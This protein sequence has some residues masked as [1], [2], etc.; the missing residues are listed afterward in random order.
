MLTKKSDGVKRLTKK[1][2]FAL[3]GIEFKDDKI[4]CPVFGWRPLLLKE[5]NSKT[6]KHVYTWS[7]LPT[8]ETFNV[9]IDGTAYA[10]KGTCPCHCKGCY[11]TSG[12]YNCDNVIQSMGINTYLIRNYPD[13]V[14]AALIAQI[15]AE[16]L[17]MVRIDA[18]G[19]IENGMINVFRNVVTACTDTKFWTY[20][21][22]K[23]VETAFDDLDNINIVKSV[24]PGIGFNYGHCDYIMNAFEKLSAAGEK[25]YICRCGV[26]KNQHCENCRGCIDNKYVLFV[27]HSTEYCAEKDP[28]YPEL[29]AL[30][31]SQSRDVITC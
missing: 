30:I 1:D 2:I 3:H 11:A 4:L 12:R 9:S 14:T 10:I 19:D 20:T 25:V 27:E 13:F 31:E 7:T 22:N 5:G 21:K 8:N 29:K 17:E 18:S 28:L 16:K 23:T 15:Q 6:G 24:L 26:D